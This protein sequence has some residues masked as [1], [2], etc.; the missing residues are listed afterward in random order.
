M[1]RLSSVT[2]EF[3]EPTD[4]ANRGLV[5]HTVGTPECDITDTAA[6]LDHGEV[7]E[8]EED[9]TVHR[10][11]SSN[12]YMGD[13]DEEGAAVEPDHVGIPDFRD[14]S[15]NDLENR[16]RGNILAYQ[17]YLAEYF[18]IN[19]TIEISNAYLR[20]GNGVNQIEHAPKKS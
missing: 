4:T 19:E 13:S 17:R 11:S 20:R 6:F 3:I 7:L 5:S 15:L 2:E 12:R 18:R 1:K 16:Y 8:P 10:T 14:A 9:E